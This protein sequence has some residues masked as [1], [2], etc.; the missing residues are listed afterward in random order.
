MTDNDEKKNHHRER[1]RRRREPDD[2]LG[3]PEHTDSISHDGT[4]HYQLSGTKRWCIRPTKKLLTHFDQLHEPYE[5]DDTTTISSTNF[6]YQRQN[7]K[8][9]STFGKDKKLDNGKE[10]DSIND[11][12]TGTG[13]I[14]VDCHQG[15]VFIIN[16]RLWYHQ[17]ILP[18]QP[19]PS[20]SYARDFWLRPKRETRNANNE[21]DQTTTTAESTND[22]GKSTRVRM[23]DDDDDDPTK[24][25]TMTNIDGLYAVEDIEEGTIIFR[26]DTMPDI[27]LHRSATNSNCDVVEVIDVDGVEIQAVVSTR[28]IVAGEFFCMPESDDDEGEEEGEEEIEDVAE[29]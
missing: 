22:G 29:E 25:I 6:Y 26:E 11:C 23:N 10:S 24:G 21:A 3:R 5:W 18:P 7:K 13:S 1:R 15:D 2:L 17:T 12:K 8:S 9:K 19:D 14:Q 28:P 16:T 27:E 20:V 4:W